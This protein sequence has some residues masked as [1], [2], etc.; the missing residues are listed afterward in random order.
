MPS[1]YKFGTVHQIRQYDSGKNT[2]ERCAGSSP[3]LYWVVV[4]TPSKRG[5]TRWWEVGRG[6][7]VCYPERH[8]CILLEISRD[9]SKRGETS[10]RKVA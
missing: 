4:G 3:Y 10:D 5:T 7:C 6:L 8:K 1:S 2:P 9:R